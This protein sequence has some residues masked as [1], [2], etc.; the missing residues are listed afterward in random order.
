MP[1]PTPT[2]QCN[3]LSRHGPMLQGFVWADAWRLTSKESSLSSA[4]LRYHLWTV[5]H[6]I[7]V[8]REW[9]NTGGHPYA[10][11]THC[12]MTQVSRWHDCDNTPNHI[13]WACPGAQRF[14]QRIHIILTNINAS[15]IGQLNL[16]SV[17]SLG[18]AHNIT[19]K[20]MAGSMIHIFAIGLQVLITQDRSK[21]SDGLST[22]FDLQTRAIDNHYH[23][24]Y[25]HFQM[26]LDQHL[27]GLLFSFGKKIL[28]FIPGD[29][30]A[31]LQGRSDGASRDNP[32]HSGA[33]WT[34]YSVASGLAIFDNCKYIGIATNNIA[35]YTAMCG[36]LKDLRDKCNAERL[37][38]TIPRL[39]RV[40]VR[41]DSKLII[42]QIFG[43]WKISDP[44]LITIQQQC[45]Q[46]IF[47]INNLGISVCASWVPRRFNQRADALANFAIDQF[48]AGYHHPLPANLPQT[49]INNEELIY[50]QE[51]NSAIDK[52]VTQ[53]HG[54]VAILDKNNF[55]KQITE[56]FADQ[57]S[58]D[59]SL[60]FKITIPGS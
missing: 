18:T 10:A 31:Q 47:E 4:T 19:N 6:R 27:N 11:C 54:V 35:E 28:P 51:I 56:P 14:W 32:G 13:I 16:A 36:L 52:I 9:A 40:Q 30:N 22:H 45:Q 29:P 24:L 5:L 58:F 38:P 60:F 50:H 53:W 26:L 43:N 25:S 3:W 15:Y 44:L 2:G 42:Q 59:P 34:I 8:S 46:Y 23:R 41:A 7:H 57:M 39:C 21:I 1:R 37:F 20:D 55:I 48:I 49:S 12:N 17:L 33:G